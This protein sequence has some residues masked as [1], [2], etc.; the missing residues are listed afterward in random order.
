MLLAHLVSYFF[1]PSMFACFYSVT[2]VV[3]TLAV[4]DKQSNA[5]DTSALNPSNVCITAT[6]NSIAGSSSTTVPFVITPH[7]DISTS[8]MMCSTSL[9]MTTS[10]QENSRAVTPVDADHETNDVDKLIDD[11]KWSSLTFYGATP[12]IASQAEFFMS[13]LSGDIAIVKNS[14]AEP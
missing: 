9:L 10:T 12:N 13:G 4:V 7:T 1:F 3:E 5:T 2:A 14:G 8:G 11:L 6:D